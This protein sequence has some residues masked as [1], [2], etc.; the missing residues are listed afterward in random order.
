MIYNKEFNRWVTK[1]GLIYRFSKRQNKLILCKLSLNTKGYLNITLNK[2]SYKAHRIIYET[3]FGKIPQNYV[4]D[5]IN[6]IRT[7]NRLEN[8]R[9]VTVLENNRNPLT[10]LHLSIAHRKK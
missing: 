6:T 7:D 5:H 9:C 3:F 10:L 1:S 8:L 2:K 4:I